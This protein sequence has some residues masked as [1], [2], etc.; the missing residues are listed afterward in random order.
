MMSILSETFA[1]FTETLMNAVVTLPEKPV[2]CYALASLTGVWV[3][4]EIYLPIRNRRVVASATLPPAL[5]SKMTDETFEKARSYSL[6]NS[7]FSLVSS[8]YNHAMSVVF[9]LGGYMPFMWA[10]SK[11]YVGD[12]GYDDSNTIMIS[13]LF[14]SLCS[15]VEMFMSL[16]WSLWKTFVIEER[17]GFNKQT[18]AFYIKDTVKQFFVSQILTSVI[19]GLLLKVIEWGGD[20]FFIYAWLLVVTISVVMFAVYAD[21]IAPLFDTFVGLPAGELRERI[22]GLAQRLDFPL[23]KLYVVK[24]SVRSS[25]SNAYFYGFFKNKRIVL[26]DTLLPPD[27]K[28]FDE[29]D[30]VEETTETTHADDGS[31]KE[32]TKNEKSLGCSVDEIEAV[33]CHELGHWN[34]NHVLKGFVTG[35]LQMLVMMYTFQILYKNDQLYADFGFVAGEQP[36]VVGLQLVLGYMLN[37]ILYVV[38][39]ALTYRTRVYEYQA[40]AFAKGHGLSSHLKS[41]LIKLNHDNLSFPVSDWLYSAINH[42]HPTLLDRIAAIDGGDKKTD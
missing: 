3:W 25:H 34:H 13:I 42:S 4:S 10:L 12:L 29:D 33:L 15:V 14:V 30:K 5:K 21:F 26:F 6:D 36:L 16:P 24:G 38:G 31:D 37:P 39:I 9:I 22:E 35:Q 28:I 2:L 18:L 17:H 1:T 19:M 8:V 41:A 32:E 11:K 40:D 27:M 7:A 20:N 23:K